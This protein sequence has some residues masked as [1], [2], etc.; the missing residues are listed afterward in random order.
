MFQSGWYW[1]N[2]KPQGNPLHDVYF[3]DDTNGWAV[4]QARKILPWDGED[5][6]AQTSGFEEHLFDVH[7]I[8]SQ[9]GWAV[10]R[11]KPSCTLPMGEDPPFISLI[12]G[13]SWDSRLKITSRP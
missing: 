3:T 4:G 2:P 12:S 6:T 5:W 13:M 11:M 1:Q 8:N 7:F 10:G 9:K